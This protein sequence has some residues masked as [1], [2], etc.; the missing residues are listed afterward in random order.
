MPDLT[1]LLPMSATTARELPAGDG[2]IG[3]P[4]Y[5]GIRLLARVEKGRAHLV[6]RNGKELTAEFPAIAAE[7][8]QLA[9][10]ETLLLD[11]E[12]V[13]MRGGRPAR[14]QMLQRRRLEGGGAKNA[15]AVFDLL[16]EGKRNRMPEP[17]SERRTALEA[18]LKRRASPHLL[19]S[20]YSKDLHAL[21]A[22]AKNRGAEG[23]IAKRTDA[24]YEPGKRSGA[25]L[26]LKLE[27][28]Q[29]FVIGGWTPPQ[30]SRPFLGAILVGYYEEEELI[31]AGKVGTGFT[32]RDLE[33]LL[34]RLE[35]R[36]RKTSPFTSTPRVKSAH[37]ARPDLVAEIRFTEWTRDGRLRHPAFL[38]LR[39]D[40]D[41]RE[42]VRE[43]E[44][45]GG[46]SGAGG[47]RT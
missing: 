45:L 19:L 6:T 23:I 46:G 21:L 25:W 43:P 34:G 30:R 2:W 24:P 16:I 15:F 32:H 22:K 3:E 28:E 5:D 1:T 11:G 17:W 12:V 39:E 14:F 37:W 18:L 40:K 31:Y 33:D 7:L 20:T 41:A 27:H 35:R 13:A 38:G 36:E 47:T 4:K 29:E 42:V 8:E 10:G 26:K 9:G 44:S